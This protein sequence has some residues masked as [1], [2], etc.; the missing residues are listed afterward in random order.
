MPSKGDDEIWVPV[1][2]NLPLGITKG[3]NPTECAPLQ[4]LFGPF[5]II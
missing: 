4:L 5:T 2:I 3:F 1:T